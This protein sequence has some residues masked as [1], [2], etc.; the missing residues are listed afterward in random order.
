MIRPMIYQSVTKIA[1]ALVLSLLWDRWINTENS[2][3]LFRDAFFV[4]GIFFLM[5][6][7]I[8]YLKLDGVKL[9][10]LLEERKKKKKVKRH[11]TRDIVDFADEKIISFAELEDDERVVCRFIGNL[12][13]AFLYLIPALIALIIL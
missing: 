11:N 2:L 7:W 1:V 6:A 12:L 5:L 8:Q 13:C 3:S 10:H 9:H 4:V